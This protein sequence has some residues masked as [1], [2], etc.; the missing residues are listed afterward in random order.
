VGVG[1]AGG[2]VIACDWVAVVVSS[3]QPQIYPGVKQLVELEDDDVV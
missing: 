2:D 3:L 1:K